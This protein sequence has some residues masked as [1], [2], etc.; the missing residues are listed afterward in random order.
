MDFKTA[1]SIPLIFSNP[2]LYGAADFVGVA[3]TGTAI[4]GLNGICHYN[5][6]TAWIGFSSMKVG[7]IVTGA[8]PII[9]FALLVNKLA[10]PD[11]GSPILDPYEEAW[12]SYEV[13]WE[14]EELKKTIKFDSSCQMKE[15][16][17]ILSTAQL[18]V[19][20]RNLEINHELDL[21]R[22]EMSLF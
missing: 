11:H 2:I 12:R 15:K 13:E 7:A 20:F 22:Q 17:C 6:A 14:L 5:A 9:G 1:A 16:P 21:L 18:E 10:G 3:K 8:L 4:G 19:K